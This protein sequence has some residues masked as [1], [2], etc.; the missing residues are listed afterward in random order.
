MSSNQATELSYAVRP[1]VVLKY[2]G[3]LFLVLAALTAVPL[4]VSLPLERGLF[5]LRTSLVIA[6]LAAVGALLGRLR[7]PERIQ[8][9]EALVIVA[10]IFVLAPL[11][12]AY[13][14]T[15]YGRPFIDMFFEAVSAVTTTGLSTTGGAEG[16]AP[17]FLLLRA[18]MQW[19]GGLG[20]VVL[21]LALVVRP[22]LVARQLSGATDDEADLVGSTKVHAR[23]ALGVYCT[24]TAVGV[25]LLL[26]AGERPLLAMT[27][28]FAVVSTTGFSGPDLR[29][30]DLGGWPLQ[31]VVM[32][33]CLSA[34]ASLSMYKRA[35][36]KGWRELFEDVQ[37]R[38]MLGAGAVTCLVLGVLLRFVDHLDWWGVLHQAP[39][40]GYSAQT[41]ACF[42]SADLG[43]LGSA[44]RLVLIFS[45][46][47]GAC[48]GSTGGGIKIIRLLI[49]LRL[50]QVRIRRTCLP[51]N[52]VLVPRLAGRSL[53]DRETQD[54]LLVIFL[55]IGVVLLSWLSFLTYGHD[56]LNSLFEVV[57]ATATA[58][59]STGI[60]RPDLAPFLKGVLCADMLLGR[61]EVVAML[62]LV[63]PGSWVGRQ[64]EEP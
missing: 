29:R 12:M 61:L 41:T 53:E 58:G 63:Y 59:L 21:S 26:G 5:A 60:S 3:Q 13:P 50:A 15:A 14:M 25:A 51:R 27:D 36:R 2:V 1:R 47:V 31:S 10:V 35:F 55:F 62:A 46:L 57:S 48:A 49:V 45:M 37:L 39:L 23:N 19:Y 22:G 6:V 7:R 44:A 42:S 56:P 38:G 4:L 40:L 18:W 52:A 28:A 16:K 17:G 24:L 43:R 8:S 64:S 20:F 34:A 30:F 11:I 9:N 32:L 33:G 54:A